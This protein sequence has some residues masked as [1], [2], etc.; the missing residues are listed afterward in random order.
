MRDAIKLFLRLKAGVTAAEPSDSVSWTINQQPSPVD[1]YYPQKPNGQTLL[2]IHGMTPAGARDPRMKNLCKKIS[3]IGFIVVAPNF[4]S[5][6]DCII[7]DNQVGDMTQSMRLL[8]ADTTLCPSRKISIMSISFSGSI[9]VC[10]AAHNDIKNSVNALLSIGYAPCGATTIRELISNDCQDDYA[11]YIALKS[12]YHFINQVDPL[13]EQGYNALIQDDYASEHRFDHFIASLEA[14]DASR[15]K[16]YFE[17]IVN[18]QSTVPQQ[19]LEQ[20][21]F[22]YLKSIFNFKE[23][24]Q[25]VPFP[26]YIF[27]DPNDKILLT[28]HVRRLQKEF[29]RQSSPHT[30]DITALLNH[31]NT[32]FSFKQSMTILKTLWHYSRFLKKALA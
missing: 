14:A 21:N 24:L 30:I 6:A 19:L 32:E 2:M 23:A 13:I 11:H 7:L 31:A 26:V 18:Y 5:I 16:D 10:A 4:K 8:L 1:V 25:Q 27:Q 17:G 28:K 12:A 29:I 3:E 9:A 22:S 15:I 20:I